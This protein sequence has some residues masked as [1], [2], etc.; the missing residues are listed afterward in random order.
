VFDGEP[1]SIVKDLK[2]YA[3]PY[4]LTDISKVWHSVNKSLKMKK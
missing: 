2:W 1:A 3:N 4:A